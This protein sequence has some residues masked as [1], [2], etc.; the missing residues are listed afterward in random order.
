MGNVAL[1]VA[2]L[3]VASEWC[4]GRLATVDEL[5]RCDDLDITD[6]KRLENC[7]NE[8]VVYARLAARFAR[9]LLTHAWKE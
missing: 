6:T 9:L 3:D 8:A 7:S 5:S 2:A 1:A 4:R